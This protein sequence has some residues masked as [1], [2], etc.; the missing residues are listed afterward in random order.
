MEE[1]EL[2]H[3]NLTEVNKGW[4]YGLHML[5]VLRVNQN[6]IGIIRPDAW[7]FCQK[8]EELDL[9]FNHLT[10]LEETVFIGLGLLENLNL[11]ENTI[12]HL[13]EGVFSS[14][15]NLRSL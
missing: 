1:L 10:R 3:N 11:G 4:L 5:H 12:S 9:S 14:L 8:L 15:A 6:T 7:E 2:E 13:G